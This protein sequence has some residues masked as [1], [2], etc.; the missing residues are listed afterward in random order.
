MRPLM[1]T[2]EFS[3]AGTSNVA[4]GGGGEDV[5]S[6]GEAKIGVMPGACV[7]EDGLTATNGS[8]AAG[9]GW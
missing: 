1:R 7:C 3:N 8:R 4:G 2:P 5:E 9:M 6:V